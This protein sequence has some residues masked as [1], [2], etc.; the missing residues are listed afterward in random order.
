[1]RKLRGKAFG[2][3]SA[4]AKRRMYRGWE[5][6]QERQRVGT[7]REGEE[8]KMERKEKPGGRGHKKQG[9]QTHPLMR[10]WRGDRDGSSI[11]P[12]QGQGGAL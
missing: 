4:K 2:K 6:R 9:E 5:G 8:R 1:M 3:G 7:G 12:Q 11:G 10:P